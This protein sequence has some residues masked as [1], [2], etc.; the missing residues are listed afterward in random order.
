MDTAGDGTGTK[1]LI[2]NYSAT[3]SAVTVA[4]I[5]SAGGGGADLHR[6][7]FSI[8]DTSGMLA[9]EYGNASSLLVGYSFEILDADSNSILDL[10]DGFKIQDN[11]DFA[12]LCYDVDVKSWGTSPTNEMLVARWTFSRAGS[13][14]QL[15]PGYRIQT[16]LN[17]DFSGLL[18]HRFMVQG[19]QGY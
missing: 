6:L 16:T 13:P 9:E 17:D 8:K 15:D 18:S 5:A 14:L 4:Y 10:N 11:S 19:V 2:G 7:I 1:N 3:A 12:T